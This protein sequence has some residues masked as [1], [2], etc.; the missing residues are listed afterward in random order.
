MSKW[1]Q[2]EYKNGLILPENL[3]RTEQVF[4]MSMRKAPCLQVCLQC[5]HILNASLS[6]YCKWHTK[7]LFGWVLHGFHLL[8]FLL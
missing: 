1:L 5:A 2:R 6:S 3:I 8:R 7:M 4:Y